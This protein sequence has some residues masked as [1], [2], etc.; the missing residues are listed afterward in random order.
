[1][2]CYGGEWKPYNTILQIQLSYPTDILKFT[3]LKKSS[4]VFWFIDQ[5]IILILKKRLPNKY[6]GRSSLLVIHFKYYS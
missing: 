4:P 6:G 1:M 5:G 3:V 2:K